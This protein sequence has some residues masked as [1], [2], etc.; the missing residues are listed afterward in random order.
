MQKY[1]ALLVNS[2]LTKYLLH[3]FTLY[4]NNYLWRLFEKILSKWD[5]C[6]YR[7]TEARG[8]YLQGS[9]TYFTIL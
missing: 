9:D 1:E 4:L 2:T 5:Y 8:K 7:M 6:G 3:V